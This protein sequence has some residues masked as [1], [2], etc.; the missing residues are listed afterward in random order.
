MGVAA[1]DVDNDGDLDLYTTNYGANQLWKNRGDGSFG[2]ATA[3]SGA[4]HAS[5]SVS[6]AF[7]DYDRDGWLDLFV[8]NYVDYS[9]EKNPACFAPTSRR[10][11]CGPGDFPPLPATLLRNRGDGTFEDV[12]ARAGIA[13]K[14][15]PGLGVIAFDADADSW[16][17][18]YV[19]ND[20]ADNYLWLNRRDGTFR[21]DGLLAGVAVNRLGRPEASMGVDAG[22]FDADGDEDIFKVNLTGETNT[23][24]VNLGGGLFE[25]RTAET[26]VGRGSLPFTGFGTAWV[27]VDNDGWLD[28]PIF[29]GAVRLQEE[30]LRRGEP[31]PL[32]QT[33]QLYRNTGDGRFV[34]ST[35]EA[36]A[37]FQEPAVSRGAAF[38]DV[39]GDGD[40]DAVVAN[41]NGPA[42][43]LL[44]QAE[45]NSWLAARVT[46][47][48]R[49]AHGARVALES[50]GR[51][52]LW[53][54]VH[55]D[56]SYASA[57]DPRAHFGLG[58][59]PGRPALAVLWPDGGRTVWRDVVPRR[60]LV[61][62]AGAERLKGGRR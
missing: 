58:P 59:S 14:P 1:G 4:G 47:G 18:L 8:A 10:D 37:A 51:P 62:A 27:D 55:S 57:S 13:A 11:Y 29:N 28:L 21:E 22:D 6:A 32:A 41:S 40:L 43:L 52:T 16:P 5:W 35:E 38:G 20:G 56:G 7:L 42:W 24:Y 2:D 9:L 23:L 48:G 49:D 54:R 46:A 25:D 33:S 15:G 30:G 60:V 34:E 39:D 44:N 17:D 26:H 3:A 50:P 45:G 31:Y 53:R 36:G 12:S 19:A 61:L